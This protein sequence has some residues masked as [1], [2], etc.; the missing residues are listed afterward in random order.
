MPNT[1]QCDDKALFLLIA[2][3]DITAFKL[4][5]DLYK[6]RFYS[7][8]YKMTRSSHIAEDIVQEVFILLWTKRTQ[9]GVA[10]NPSHYLFTILYNSIYAHF[11]KLASEKRLMQGL[12]LQSLEWED[13]VELFLQAKEHRYLLDLILRQLPRQQQIAYKLSKL[14]GMS[15]EEVANHMHISPHSVKNHLQHAA[16]FIRHYFS[17]KEAI[18][19]FILLL[20]C[21]GI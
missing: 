7:A 15:R 21:Q 19:L 1:L 2:Q 4:V 6:A 14:E 16:K 9:I 11:K 8:A 12:S 18:F 3:G 20:T 17:E 10:K 5:F 13:P